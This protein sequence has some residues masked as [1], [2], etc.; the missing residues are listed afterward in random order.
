MASSGS[1]TAS[2]GKTMYVVPKETRNWLCDLVSLTTNSCNPQELYDDKFETLINKFKALFSP[3]AHKPF[4]ALCL[5]LGTYINKIQSPLPALTENS[6]NCKYCIV[7]AK[8]VSGVTSDLFVK[9]VEA[10]ND[11]LDP[12]EI[13]NTTGWYLNKLTESHPRLRDHLQMYVFSSQVYVRALYNPFSGK[14]KM[15]LTLDKDLDITDAS[16]HFYQ[17]QGYVASAV[18]GIKRTLL[19][20]S[21]VAKRMRQQYGGAEEIANMSIFM[22][23][24]GKQFLKYADLYVEKGD[25]TFME[26]LPCI[27]DLLDMLMFMGTQYGMIHNDLHTGNVFYDV[28][29]KTLRLIDF[30]RMFIAKANTPDVFAQLRKELE[31]QGLWTNGK[32]R[33]YNDFMY[34]QNKNIMTWPNKAGKYLSCLMDYIT[35]SMNMLVDIERVIPGTAHTMVDFIDIIDP[36]QTSNYGNINEQLSF[37]VPNDLENVFHGFLKFTKRPKQKWL[38]YV[39]EGVFFWTLF[40]YYLTFV[41]QSNQRMTRQMMT[42]N[43]RVTL[44]HL[45]NVHT[46]GWCFQFG[47]K[48]EIYGCFIDWLELLFDGNVVPKSIVTEVKSVSI[49]FRALNS[50]HS[51]FEKSVRGG[52][53]KA[54]SSPTGLPA[55]LTDS[56]MGARSVKVEDMAYAYLQ[57]KTYKLPRSLILRAK[58]S[59]SKFTSGYLKKRLAAWTDTYG[60]KKTSATANIAYGGVASKKHKPSNK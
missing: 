31:K 22:A 55:I 56:R 14:P 34:V 18:R 3:D 24:D 13:D 15:I 59:R 33:S 41:I 19:A 35:L 25:K 23:I 4:T 11:E 40:V 12:I 28:K 16:S 51:I 8:L 57:N 32:Y 2:R 6:A 9:V 1:N 52:D 43:T 29:T 44:E 39:G 47:G 45:Y 27:P 30:G 42:G 54:T 37:S 53:H 17:P 60:A 36:I 50:N 46:I 10:N 38:S 5:L 48:D 26:L 58:S 7:T 20:A 49:F 21:T